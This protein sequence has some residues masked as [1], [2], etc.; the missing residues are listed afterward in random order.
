MFHFAISPLYLQFAIFLY[1]TCINLT[2]KPLLG[3]I[4][5]NLPL[6]LQDL[7]VLKIV[8]F[9]THNGMPA[10]IIHPVKCLLACQY[11]Y[12]HARMQ[13]FCLHYITIGCA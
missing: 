3:L 10:Y 7:L 5:C 1:Q 9:K 11:K 12:W 13:C 6:F 2:S 4:S 8:N